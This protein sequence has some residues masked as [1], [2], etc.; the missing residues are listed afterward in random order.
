[1]DL[2][3]ISDTFP[4]YDLWWG[5]I[6]LTVGAISALLGALFASVSEHTKGLPAYSTIENNGLIVIAI[7]AYMLASIIISSCW[8]TL[9]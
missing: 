2:S 9:R 8:Q 3:R 7:G 4:H 5:W 6:T 1:M